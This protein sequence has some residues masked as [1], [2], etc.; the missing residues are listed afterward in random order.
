MNAEGDEKF[1]LAVVAHSFDFEGCPGSNS[2]LASRGNFRLE[3][4]IQ[5]NAQGP[6]RPSLTP[7]AKRRRTGKAASHTSSN[8]TV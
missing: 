5:E 1:N 2:L 4:P 7:K 6:P 8:Y 3:Q